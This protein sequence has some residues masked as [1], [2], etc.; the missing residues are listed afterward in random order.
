MISKQVERSEAFGLWSR[1]RHADH[2]VVEASISL[3]AV[4][5]QLLPM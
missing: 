3:L 2:D 1:S 5:K 4:G